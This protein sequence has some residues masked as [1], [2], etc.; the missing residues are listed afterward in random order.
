[1][2]GLG[3]FFV[4]FCLFIYFCAWHALQWEEQALV[5]TITNTGSQAGVGMRGGHRHG[6]TGC[7]LSCASLCMA[8]W[9]QQGKSGLVLF[10]HLTLWSDMPCLPGGLVLY[11]CVYSEVNPSCL[12]RGVC[13]TLPVISGCFQSCSLGRV[14]QVLLPG[15]AVGSG[16]LP[17][18]EVLRSYS[19]EVCP[20]GG[21]APAIRPSLWM[22]N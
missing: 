5:S 7:W 2:D 20:S 4:L 15:K 13:G 1:M 18:A 3:V 8:T 12:L 21:M 10:R 14:L 9:A 11:T 16:S 17:L 22:W 6:L 19:I